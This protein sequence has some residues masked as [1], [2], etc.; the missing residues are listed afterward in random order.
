MNSLNM[1][2]IVAPKGSTSFTSGPSS[3]YVELFLDEPAK[4]LPSPVKDTCRPVGQSW[5]YTAIV[6]FLL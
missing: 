2:M 1:E 6:F 4:E 5:A 3:F